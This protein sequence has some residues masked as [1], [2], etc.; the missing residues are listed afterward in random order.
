MTDKK[1][2][3]T[4]SSVWDAVAEEYEDV[5]FHRA[6]G[7]YPANSFRYEIL[8]EFL[9]SVP[10]GKILDAGC[11]PGLMT[12]LLQ[13]Q[14]WKVVACDYSDRM[15]DTSKKMAQ[16]ENLPDVYQKMSVLNLSRIGQ[17]FDYVILNGVLPY[18]SIEEEPKVFSEIRKVLRPG[19]TLLASHYNLYFDIFGLDKWSLEAI[20]NNVL[21]PVGLPKTELTLATERIKSLL[22]QPNKVLDQE[23]TMKLE[24]PLTYSEKLRRFGFEEFDQAFYNLF[25]LPSKFEK[26][27]NQEVREKLERKLRR[28]R[29]ALLLYRTFV[30]FA[31]SA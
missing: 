6:D 13:K 9:N 1:F 27:Q 14:G 11:G 8:L 3:S 28:D 15:I 18:I 20:V 30:S 21:E 5:S 26:D 31:K 10:K 17:Q 2:I 16:A 12:R 25:Y 4:P 29:R 7:A 24:D 23:K 19:G 22:N